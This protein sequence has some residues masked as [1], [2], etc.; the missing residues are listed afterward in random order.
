[1]FMN[2]PI[3]S[4]ILPCY[5]QGH[6]LSEALGSIQYLDASFAEVIIV[7]DGSTD[8]ET[9]ALLNQLKQ[10][11]RHVIFQ[12]NGG[13]GHARNV[14]IAASKGKYILPLDADN[15][16][17]KGYVEKAIEVLEQNKSV[18]VVYSDCALFGAQQGIQVQG[19][20][21]LQRLMLGNFID[22]CAVIRKDV[23]LEVGCYDQ[24]KIMG[25]E[26]WDLWLRIAFAGHRFHYLAEA[27]FEYRV[28]EHT[29]YRLKKNPVR[30]FM[31]LLEKKY[32]PER[33]QRKIDANKIYAGNFTYKF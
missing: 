27:L 13:L 21:N 16:I 9:I 17:R 32:F 4:V 8:E 20:F 11:G 19:E 31:R 7:N 14:G 18:A 28:T 3:V 24:M 23:L 2:L 29:V 26:D 15:K 22:A 12:E 30:F 10:E 1:M 5:N 6:F 25:Y 33:Y